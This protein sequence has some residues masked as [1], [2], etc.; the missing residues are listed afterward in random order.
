LSYR[1][2]YWKLRGRGEQIRLLLHELGQPYE[3]VHVTKEDT[4]A[5]LR[6]EGPGTLAFGSVP[7]LQDGALKLV[8]GPAIMNYLG[9]KHGLMPNDPRDAATTE[10]MVLGAED[11]RMAYFRSLGNHAAERQAAFVAGDWRDRWLPAWEGLLARNGD[12]GVLIGPALTHADVAV[13]DALD[14]SVTGVAGA[15]LDGFPRVERFYASVAA[16]PAIAAYLAS[17]Q[18]IGPRAAS[19]A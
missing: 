17:D 3:D 19:G 12:H 15:T 16:R 10:A 1:L 4:F 6:R 8:Q 14:Q 18:R 7:M 5:A 11:M 13:W 9:R 2:F